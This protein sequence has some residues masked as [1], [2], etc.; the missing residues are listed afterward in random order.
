MDDAFSKSDI[1]EVTISI[2]IS[3]SGHL[4]VKVTNLGCN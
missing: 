4:P 2:K 1:M 3:S